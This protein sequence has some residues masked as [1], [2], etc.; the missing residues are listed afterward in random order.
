MTRLQTTLPS[1]DRGGSHRGVLRTRPSAEPRP[2]G[3][4][5]CIDSSAD[6]L[7]YVRVLLRQTG[8]GMLTAANVYDALILLRVTAPRMVIVS[9]DIRALGG[10]DTAEA[11]RSRPIV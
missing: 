3:R 8:Y 10:T 1:R 4:I 6:V 11:F 2:T 9:A 7:A 5:L